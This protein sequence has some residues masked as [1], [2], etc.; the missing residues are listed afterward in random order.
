M[1]FPQGH[2]SDSVRDSVAGEQDVDGSA[3]LRQKV[4]VHLQRWLRCHGD[5]VRGHG[6]QTQA[7]CCELRSLP[8]LRR[9][10]IDTAHAR[11]VGQLRTATQR[12]Q[13]CPRPI[14]RLYCSAHALTWYGRR[15]NDRRLV[16]IVTGASR[17]QAVSSR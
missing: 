2:G 8:D 10:V 14:A 9:P 17:C 13:T 5:R 1:T 7:V 3:G 4:Q 16:A 6:A 15:P 11:T 12:G